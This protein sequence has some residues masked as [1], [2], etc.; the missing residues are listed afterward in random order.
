MVGLT[1]RTVLAAFAA[2]AAPPARADDYPARAV[3]IVVPFTP[4]GA[5]DL[6][7]RMVGARLEQKW[8]K[9]FVIENRPGAG[10][11]IGASTVAKAQPDGYTLLIAPSGTLAVNGTLYKS[12]P[13]DPL[14]DF[15]PLSL[16]AQ[17]PFALVLNPALPVKSVPEL[18]AYAK[19][20][21][22]PLIYATVGPGLPHHLFG[23]LFKT[24]T[25]IAMTPV[26][27]KGSLPA[28]NDVIAGHVPLMFCDLGPAGPMIT[29]GKVRAL[30]VTTRTRVAAV[31]DV[32]PLAEVGVPGFDAASWQMFLAP[33]KTPSEVV[34]KLH[35]ELKATLAQ[36]EIGDLIAKNGMVPMENTSVAALQAFVKSEVTRW[37]KVVQDAGIAQSMSQ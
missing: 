13:Y 4:G 22:E 18:V 28:L 20:K 33:A 10:S 27:Y 16:A 37:G 3:T 25:G 1:R 19:V 9:P 15:V 8:G 26:P 12:L 36:S 7:A 24:M 11:I 14:G 30:G 31:P 35:A 23:E 17:T 2:G 6:L 5:G 32:P 21:G 34:Q 29:A